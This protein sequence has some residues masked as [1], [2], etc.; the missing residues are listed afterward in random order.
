MFLLA[1]PNSDRQ[2]TARMCAIAAQILPG[3]R[4]WT[5]P[6]GPRLISTPQ[7]L[8]RAAGMVAALDPPPGCRGVIVSAFGDPGAARL[9]TRL[10]L[11]VVG[12]GA[13]AARA[14][15]GGGRSFAVATTTP[16]LAGRIDRLMRAHG[17]A[18]RYLGCW[19][20]GD[21]SDDPTCQPEALDAALLAAVGAAAA[22]GAQAVIIGGGPLADAALR[23]AG[24][25]PVPLVQPIPEAARLMARIGES[26]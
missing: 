3:I 9:R 18:G 26:R 6:A 5:A 22:G 15:A 4:G 19:L 11:P 8:D 10:G 14:A 17:G 20:T 24:S 7:D 12:I 1:N 13:A 23:L 16:A 21:G 25:A 2:T